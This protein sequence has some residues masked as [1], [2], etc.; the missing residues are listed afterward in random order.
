MAVGQRLPAAVVLTTV[1]MIIVRVACTRPLAEIADHPEPGSSVW[2]W[3]LSGVSAATS[4]VAAVDPS[5]S[6]WK[7]GVLLGVVVGVTCMAAHYRLA[8]PPLLWHALLTRDLHAGLFAR[9]QF[10]DVAGCPPPFTWCPIRPGMSP[11]V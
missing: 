6:A 2:Q 7:I 11:H 10:H 1:R 3:H 9:R 8:Y 5:R 4:L